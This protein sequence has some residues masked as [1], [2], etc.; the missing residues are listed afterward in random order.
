MRL[1]R[2]NSEFCLSAAF[3]VVASFASYMSEELGFVWHLTY[4]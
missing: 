2:A 1:I 4:L 3:S